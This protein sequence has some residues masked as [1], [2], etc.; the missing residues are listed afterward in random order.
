MLL[1]LLLLVWDRSARCARAACHKLVESC[2][3]VT[4]QL[5]GDD[6][7]TMAEIGCHVGAPG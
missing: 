1:R 2:P 5:H 7:S 4:S 6:E 3:W